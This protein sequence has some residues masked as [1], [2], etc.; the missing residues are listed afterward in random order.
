MLA[1]SG[2][3]PRHAHPPVAAAMARCFSA[4]VW[5]LAAGMRD[6]A[7]TLLAAED[8]LGRVLPEGAKMGADTMLECINI[9]QLACHVI[10][11]FFR[12]E[13]KIAT[14]ER[15]RNVAKPR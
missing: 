6:H 11:R 15:R 3:A 12:I 4:I 10:V 9:G 7:R 14:S 13:I 1:F 8:F 2:P 5:A